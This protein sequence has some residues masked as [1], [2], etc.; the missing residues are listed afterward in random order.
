MRDDY[1]GP[2]DPTCDLT[3]FSRRALARLGREYMLFGHLLNRAG[4]VPVYL[5]L[6]A[7]AREAVA[8]DE[9]MGASPIYTRRMQRL[10]GFGGDDVAT[11][12]KGMQ[13]DVG[14]AHQYMDVRYELEG[15][16]RGS[17]WLASCGALLEVEPYGEAAVR[18]MC[19]AIEDPTFD[20]T[21]VA[22][23]PRARCR[24][25]HR[26][27]RMPADRVPHCRWEVT[28]DPAAAPIVQRPISDEVGRSLLATIAFEPPAGSPPG[29]WEDYA[30]AFAPNLRLEDF[31]Y[32]ALVALAREFLVQ[33]HLLIHALMLAV[34][35]R[36]DAET[37]R[38]IATAQW[39]GAGAVAA[40][41][42]HRTLG[43]RDDGPE[44]IA[45]VLQLH[46]AFLPGYTR[47][48][49]AVES[50]RVRVAIEDCPAL[51]ERAGFSWLA[52]LGP[53]AHPALDAMARAV[54]PHARCEPATPAAGAVLAW[55]IVVDAAAAPAAP[56]PE[57][58]MVAATSTARF[59]VRAG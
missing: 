20:A 14:F 48:R 12:L 30:A 1:R 27:P 22:T 4:L 31:S 7:E 23:N 51:H 13:L 35:A 17:F 52:L 2:F 57:V 39:I 28:I 56:P 33:D 26:P 24:P 53:T 11:I 32:A 19:H 15:P 3:H 37:A 46:P 21:A 44:A 55:E 25:V 47:T 38:R 29:G 34:A 16:S 42:M 18:S 58:A 54:N 45:K 9:W 40:A 41:R 50:D 43:L 10:M 59:V 49:L 8:I 5:R 36:S 6:G